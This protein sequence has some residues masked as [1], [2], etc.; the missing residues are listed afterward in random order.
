MYLLTTLLL[1]V[2]AAEDAELE[3]FVA[4]LSATALQLPLTFSPGG[5]VPLGPVVPLL[6]GGIVTPGTV[7]PLLAG[8]S[9]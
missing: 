2:T 5:T 1:Q 7:V 8:L 6:A 4:S 3:L 9:T